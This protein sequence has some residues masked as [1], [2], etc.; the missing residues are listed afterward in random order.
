MENFSFCSPTKFV[1]GK[2]VE[3][4]IG[5]ELAFRGAHKVLIHF[6]GKSARK[7]GVLDRIEQSFDKAGIEYVEVGGVR[8]NPEIT[9][10]RKG[11]AIA[12]EEHI[13]WVLAVGGGSVIDSSKA[14]AMGAVAHVDPWKFYIGEAS[15]ESALPIAC[16]LTI[17][18]AGSEAGPF[19][20][21]SNDEVG[22]KSGYGADVLTPKVS[23]MNPELTFTL[24][25]YQT[26]AGLTDMFA[27]VLERFFCPAG[28]VPVSDNMLIALM[29]TIRSV[30][31]Q[32]LED[33]QNYDARAN[34]MWNAMLCHQGLASCG[35]IEDWA[36]HA[37]EHQLSAYNPGVTHGAGLAVMFPAWMRYVYT[38]DPARFVLYGNQVFGLVPTGNVLADA[39]RAIEATEQLFN[40]FG[41]PSTLKELDIHEKDI[42]ALVNLLHEDRGE[43]FGFFKK[44]TMQ[45]ARKIYEMAL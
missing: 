3:T 28:S 44:L 16:V 41:M 21:L 6:G 14:I 7:S 13:D 12:K 2:G 22:L 9:L 8:P 24:P 31:P 37:M 42:D 38:T 11:I 25:A 19:T 26:G 36:T 43:T 17:P 45:D 40:S 10:V 39:R 30:G 15:A 32:V 23:F 4:Q 29:R 35:R 5:E 20:I 18:A 1:F 33:P 27:H 34:I